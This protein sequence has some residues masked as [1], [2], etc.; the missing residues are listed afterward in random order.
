[1]IKYI[2]AVKQVI[3]AYPNTLYSRTKNVF[4]ILYWYFIILPFYKKDFILTYLW[5]LN[6]IW[7]KY[8][9][10][11]KYSFLIPT[12]DFWIKYLEY[13]YL[14]KWDN[15]IDIWANVWNHTLIWSLKWAYTYAFEPNNDYIR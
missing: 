14:W 7:N 3:F 2:L 8:M 10:W 5:W 12:I 11:Q 1:M 6:M 15:F 13:N 4:K 9:D